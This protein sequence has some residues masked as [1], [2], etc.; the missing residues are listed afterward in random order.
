MLCSFLSL[1]LR[2]RI[3]AHLPP[4]VRS[5]EIRH[6][7]AIG[8][9]FAIHSGTD[10]VVPPVPPRTGCRRNGHNQQQN[11]AGP[12]RP[13]TDNAMHAAPRHMPT[14][15]APRRHGAGRAM[16]MAAG[17]HDDVL[18]FVYPCAA[19]GSTIPAPPAGAGR[20]CDTPGHTSRGL[21]PGLS[22]L[23]AAGLAGVHH[24]CGRSLA[25]HPAAP[26]HGGWRELRWHPFRRRC[27]PVCP[28]ACGLPPWGARGRNGQGLSAGSTRCRHCAR[29]RGS[30]RAPF[31]RG[32]H[33]AAPPAT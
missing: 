20:A 16:A 33:P 22:C 6:V 17:A 31:R 19:E 28:C 11:H 3:P 7:A 32:E 21:A 27:V 14:S 25:A 30:F 9:R 12:C 29:L 13:G 5:L 8:P 10:G 23:L 26:A 24:A 4:R 2:V 15:H 18:P 1:C